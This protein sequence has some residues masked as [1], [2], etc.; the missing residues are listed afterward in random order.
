VTRHGPR[1]PTAERGGHDPIPATVGFCALPCVGGSLTVGAEHGDV[2]VHVERAG[3]PFCAA[4]LT[5]DDALALSLWLCAHVV[6]ERRRAGKR[7]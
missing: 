3:R 4:I 7:L 2:A 1:R 6:D 5:K